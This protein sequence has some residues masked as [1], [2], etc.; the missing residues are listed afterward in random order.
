MSEPENTEKDVEI[1]PDCT[2]NDEFATVVCPVHHIKVSTVEEET[3]TITDEQ[4]VSNEMGSWRGYIFMCP[5]CSKPGIMA[6]PALGERC[7]CCGRRILIKSKVVTG[8]I[9]KIEK[10]NV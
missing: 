5:I 7:A 9:R 4:L 2:C 10:Q 6:N 8:V 3:L 1:A